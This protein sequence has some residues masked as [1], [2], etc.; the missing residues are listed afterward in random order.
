MKAQNDKGGFFGTMETRLRL[1]AHDLIQP[2]LHSRSNI[3]MS[4]LNRGLT[5]ILFLGT[6]YD[7]FEE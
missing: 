6:V 3:H 5:P 2:Y 4:P 7:R 1:R